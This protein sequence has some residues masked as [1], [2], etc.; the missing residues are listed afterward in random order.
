MALTTQ[1]L[2]DLPQGVWPSPQCNP[3]VFPR[4][5]WLSPHRVLAFSQGVC[6]ALTI[7]NLRVLPHGVW[8]SPPRVLVFSQGV[9]RLHHTESSCLATR[10]VPLTTRGHFLGS[11]I[12]IVVIMYKMMAN[13]NH[14][15]NDNDHNDNDHNDNDDLLGCSWPAFQKEQISIFL[16]KRTNFY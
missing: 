6:V 11:S 14:K 2:C 16:R 1:N 13:S 8:P 3:C 7:Q 15:A 10:G 12:L 4:G 9:Y 5:V